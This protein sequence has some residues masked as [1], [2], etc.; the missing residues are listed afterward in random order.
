MR[1]SISKWIIESSL[2]NYEIIEDKYIIGRYDVMFGTRIRGGHIGEMC[3]GFDVC[4]GTS[5]ELLNKVQDIY[6]KFMR[7]NLQ[8]G[9]LYFAGLRGFSQIK[10][11]HK[12]IDYM[13]WLI[14]KESELLNT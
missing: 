9:N 2:Y 8:E 6:S 3:F 10:P 1:Q 7:K 12:D 11:I 13:K 5:E 14:E 4:C